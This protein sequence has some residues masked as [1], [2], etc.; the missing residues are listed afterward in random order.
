MTTRLGLMPGEVILA[1]GDREVDTIDRVRRLIN[2]YEE[3]EPIRMTI[4]RKGG[5]EVIEGSL[6]P[7]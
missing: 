5:E 3:D 6:I 7:Y 4:I 2:S 1:V